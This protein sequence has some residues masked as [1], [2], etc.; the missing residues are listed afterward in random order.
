[1]KYKETVE[2]PQEVITEQP[3]SEKNLRGTFIDIIKRRISLIKDSIQEIEY[4]FE[5]LKSLYET[6]D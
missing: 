3:I 1:M 4:A 5:E 2:Q 6:D